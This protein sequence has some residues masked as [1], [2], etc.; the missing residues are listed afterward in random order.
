MKA[1]R[2][3]KVSQP[4]LAPGGQIRL[5][6][7]FVGTQQEIG[8]A[9]LA[10]EIVGDADNGGHGDGWVRLQHYLDFSRIDIETAGFKHVSLATHDLEIAV[11]PAQADI[12][13]VKPTLPIDH[14]SGRLGP[15]PIPHH[16]A[17]AADLNL[18][19]LSIGADLPV[20][21]DYA[22]LVVR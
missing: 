4:F 22:E 14:R 8:V 21:G 20:G 18:A 19:G 1:L 9:D 15:V 7:S 11:G 3:F 2:Y 5:R 12:A 10:I 6:G 13:R 16:H 17:M